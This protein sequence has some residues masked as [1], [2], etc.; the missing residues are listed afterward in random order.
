MARNSSGFGC[1]NQDEV[2][3]I[4]RTILCRL[5]HSLLNLSHV[6]D[7]T[8]GIISFYRDQVRQLKSFVRYLFFLSL[9]V[10]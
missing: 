7:V 6:E 9:F 10:C 1:R 2:D 3:F 8:V 4:L 5:T